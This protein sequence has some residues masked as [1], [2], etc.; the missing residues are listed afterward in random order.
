MSG[1]RLAMEWTG[2]EGAIA[3]PESGFAPWTEPRWYAVQTVARHEKSVRTQ[4]AGR[5]VD[6]FLPLQVAL[7][8]WGL[9]K[10][11][12]ELPLFS[13]YVF[14]HI[15]YRERATVLTA[16]GVIR[17]VSFNGLPFP[18]ADEEIRVLRSVSGLP[19]VQ[20]YRFLTVG[21]KVR[22]S[23]G[24]LEGLEGIVVKRKSGIRFIVSVQAIQQSI[25]VE[26]SAADL[27]CIM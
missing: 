24:A 26:V 3:S 14:A 10:V 15:P 27:Q 22:I 17:I 13:G 4:L 8:K 2:T 20:P 11:A 6:T 23:S 21:R 12:V 5:D 16:A 18:V 25:A 1:A 7:H 19:S 9:R